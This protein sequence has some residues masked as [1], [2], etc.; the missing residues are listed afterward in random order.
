[1][2]AEAWPLSEP[3]IA[4][5]I[6]TLCFA[7]YKWDAE[8]CGKRLILTDSVVLTRAEH[9]QVVAICLRLDAILGRLEAALLAQPALL[10]QLGIPPALI[11]FLTREQPDDLQLARYDVFL[12]P[13]GRWMVSEFNEDVPGGF[14]EADGL[15]SLLG[16]RLTNLAF[17][18][19]LRRAILDALR[20]YP[21]IA[22]LYATGYA[23]DL[24]HMLII[25]KWLEHEGHETVLAAPIHLTC[26]W[27]GPRFF[28]TPVD[29]AFRFYPGEWFQWLANLTTWKRALPRLPMMNPLR[30]LI[31]Q[32]KRLYALWHHPDLLDA[33]DRA[34]L[35]EHTPSTLPLERV[36]TI[37]DRSRWVL[38]NAFGRMGDTVFMGNLAHDKNWEEALTHARKQPREWLLQERFDVS[39]LRDGGQPFYPSLGVYLVNHAFAG[40][41][42]RAAHQPFINHEAYHVA[43]LVEAA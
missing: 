11:P 20:P 32:S 22:L 21:R 16:P 34:F 26:R 3:E 1:M 40:Y 8:A 13:E 18:G 9:E 33:D 27:R 31:R 43:T 6:N 17:T 12:T 25:R 36:V 10:T 30:R 7:F 2:R 42:S 24:Q 5:L 41:Y 19:G 35:A 37:E 4:E 15:P 39:P 23:E 14:N 28:Q 38:K 29:A